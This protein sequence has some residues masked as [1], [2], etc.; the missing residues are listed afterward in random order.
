MK[1]LGCVICLFGAS[2]AA[3]EINDAV[4]L[5]R[6][7]LKLDDDRREELAKEL[8]KYDA[9]FAAVIDRLSRPKH[10]DVEAGYHPD[11]HF[12]LP[13]LAEERPDDL[14]FFL[15]PES[16]RPAKPTGLVIFMHGG[17]GTSSRRAPRYSIRPRDKDDD[18]DTSAMGE[19]F[20]ELGLIAVG[21]S[22]P[23]DEESWYRWCLEE[24]DDY[25]RDVILECKHRFNIDA[26]RVF[27]LGHSMGGFGAFHHAQRQPDRFAAVIS[28][29]GSWKLGHWPAMRGTRLCFI[30]GVEDA[31]KDSRWHYTDIAYARWTDKL[32]T[33]QGLD[34]VYY[35]HPD[36]HDLYHGKPLIKK[37]LQVSH[38]LRRNPYCRHITLASPVGYSRY[39]SS[40]IKHSRWL[41]LDEST[42]GTIEYDELRADED[43]EFD[44]WEL[45]H[46]VSDRKGASIDAV[47]VEHNTI[48]VTTENVAEFTIWLHPKMIDVRRPVR[49][50]VDGDVEF[51]GLV[52]PSLAT[53]LDSYERRRDWGLVY[54]IRLRLTLDEE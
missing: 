52:R 20:D 49:V 24:A 44:D 15:V 13:N 1:L 30:N 33:Q 51:N 29:A 40:A 9:D 50:I 43:V 7:Y 54:P 6:E 25:L 36:G 2:L 41:T 37:F 23:W 3:A 17:G 53:A 14:L 46:R 12:T 16:Y 18:D 28:H 31:V 4:P 38:N 32:L 26:D 27:L 42:D 35:E 5:A 34:F 19:M 21:P 48:H 45:E 10:D 8:A 47:I 39:Y 22:A 11:A